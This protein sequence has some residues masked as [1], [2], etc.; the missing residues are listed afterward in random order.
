MRPTGTGTHQG[1]ELEREAAADPA[2]TGD[3]DHIGL[4]A[5]AQQPDGQPE[6]PVVRA[7][8]DPAGRHGEHQLPADR[9]VHL[10]QPRLPVAGRVPA[11]PAVRGQRR[12]AHYQPRVRAEAHRD[13]PGA[14]AP[15]RRGQLLLQPDQGI[16]LPALRLGGQVPEGDQGPQAPGRPSV[17][18]LQ[19]ARALRSPQPEAVRRAGPGLWVA[20]EVTDFRGRGSTAF[21]FF[22]FSNVFR[23][24]SFFLISFFFVNYRE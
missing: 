9:R 22:G 5:A 8:G 6:Q 15:D 14:G 12:P 13:V 1:D 21:P 18:G 11:R 20:G 16:L 10:P 3:Q 2:G 7:T 24:R 23:F 4:H 19:A 17:R